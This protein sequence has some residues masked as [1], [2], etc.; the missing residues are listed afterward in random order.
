D[1]RYQDHFF[2]IIDVS[3]VW[4]VGRKHSKKLKEMGIN[5][6][7]DLAC[8]NPQQIKKLFSIVMARTVSELQGVSCIEIEHSPESKKQIVASRSFGSRV[9]EL[10]DLKEAIG[11]Y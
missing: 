5:T 6:V 4:G 2:S 8:S 9:T 10:D 11:M 1:K 7:Q 3:E